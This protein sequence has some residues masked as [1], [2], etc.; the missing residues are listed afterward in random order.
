MARMVPAAIAQQSYSETHLHIRI[1]STDTVG[2]E[3][4]SCESRLPVDGNRYATPLLTGR[5]YVPA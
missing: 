4:P 3:S 2:K 5:A 1:T